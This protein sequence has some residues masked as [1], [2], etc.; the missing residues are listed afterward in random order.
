MISPLSWLWDSPLGC[1][2]VQLSGSEIRVT[3]IA[4]TF[5]NAKTAPEDG[6]HG[7]GLA[8]P[9]LYALKKKKKK[10]SITIEPSFEKNRV[11]LSANPGTTA[12][13][14]TAT[15]LTGRE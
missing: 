10:A 14:V 11:M 9:A 1:D 4:V 12:P 6:K 5:E 15:K 3:W 13:P 2:N 7:G 8:K